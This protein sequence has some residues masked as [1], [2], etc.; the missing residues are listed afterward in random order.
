MRPTGAYTRKQLVNSKSAYLRGQVDDYII[1]TIKQ[2]L[3]EDQIFVDT[4]W[5]N[6]AYLDSLQLNK[7]QTAV[8]YSGID[9]ENTH[10][11]EQRVDLHQYI[12]NNTK[13]QIHIGNTN[14]QYYFNFWTEF[15]RQYP[16]RFF[17]EAYLT[18]PKIVNKFLCLNRKMH[19]HR[20]YLLDLFDNLNISQQGLI[21]RPEHFLGNLDQDYINLIKLDTTEFRQ[22]PN[23]IYGLGDPDIWNS[24]FLNVVTETTTHTDVFISEKT[25]KPI[26]GLRPFVVLGDY[27]INSKLQDLG[28]DTF[29]DLFGNWWEDSNEWKDWRD[30]TNR[31]ADL[32]ES[33]F[34]DNTLT[35][36]N[37]LYEKLKPR[38]IANRNR[39]IEFQQENINKIR[40][41]W[42]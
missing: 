26:I 37:T 3:I 33:F 32:L 23:D 21:S 9:W 12:N 8:L 11:I 2:Q 20:E 40:N 1:K 10:C 36:L 16:D 31:L 6:Q 19:E 7:T 39:F 42:G 18:E 29:D 30:R 14:N 4:S 41:I 13:N 24:F 28:F 15:I 25:W 38:L 27:S 17:D 22:I 35:Q 5:I 34:A